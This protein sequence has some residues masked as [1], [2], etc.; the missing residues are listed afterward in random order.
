MKKIL[1]ALAA[2][3][4]VASAQAAVIANYSFTGSALTDSAAYANMTAGSFSITAGSITFLTAVGY[5]GTAADSATWGTASSQSGQPKY[6]AF[7]VT[8]SSGY[9]ITITGLSFL[10]GGTQAGPKDFGW[11]V[12]GSFYDA[13]AFPHTTT[14]NGSSFASSAQSIT[15]GAATVIGIQAW[16]A[17]ST[18]NFRVD[19]VQ[20]NGT[21]QSTAIPE[22]ATMSLLGLGAL[23][24]VLRRKM[25]K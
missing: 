19:E 6:Y 22:P 25:K 2:L 3:A 24:M 16:N 1:I 21:V 5:T 10:Y 12:G 20:L 7:T 9:E 11:S 17:T 4:M 8:P 23:A 14:G 13:T 18:G 15:I